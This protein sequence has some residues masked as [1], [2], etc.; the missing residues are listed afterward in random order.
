M[1]YLYRRFSTKILK[2]K[3]CVTL[4]ILQY[5]LHQSPNHQK[6]FGDTSTSLSHIGSLFGDCANSFLYEFSAIKSYASSIDACL[7]TVFPDLLVH[8]Q[9]VYYHLVI[10]KSTFQ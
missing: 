4:P 8:G 2:H 3:P 5:G 6:T 9:H 7:R 10:Q 1:F